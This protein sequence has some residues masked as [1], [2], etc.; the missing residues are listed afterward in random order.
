MENKSSSF[1]TKSNRGAN[2]VA[3]WATGGDIP[4]ELDYLVA[5]AA[6]MHCQLRFNNANDICPLLDVIKAAY[7]FGFDQGQKI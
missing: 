3:E 4:D 5:H 2:I 1:P 7:N 6:H